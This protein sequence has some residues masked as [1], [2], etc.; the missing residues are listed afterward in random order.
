MTLCIQVT[1]RTI[2][3]CCNRCIVCVSVLQAAC[4][5]I[6][7]LRVDVFQANQES[8]LMFQANQESVLMFQ[9]NQDSVLVF[10][11]NQDSVLV[12]LSFFNRH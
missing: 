1:W 7:Y 9:A 6:I 2:L 4:D 8:V 5:G 12:F 11:A 3:P 10:Q